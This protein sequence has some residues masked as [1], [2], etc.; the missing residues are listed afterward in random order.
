MANLSQIV[1]TIEANKETARD[2][3]EALRGRDG[4]ADAANFAGHLHVQVADDVDAGP[5]A[6]AIEDEFDVEFDVAH[7]AGS[8]PRLDGPILSNLELVFVP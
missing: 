4:V 8:R 1:D 3:A 7:P 2:A 6:V 5:F